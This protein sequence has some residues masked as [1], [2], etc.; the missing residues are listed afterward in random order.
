M[1]LVQT[2]QQQ[3]DELRARIQALEAEREGY[4][5]VKSVAQNLGVSATFIRERLRLPAFKKTYRR[6]G[7]NYSV[8]LGLFKK[9]LDKCSRKANA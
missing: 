9:Q 5:S 2:Q 4:Q 6:Q 1:A 8:H 3:I 7:R